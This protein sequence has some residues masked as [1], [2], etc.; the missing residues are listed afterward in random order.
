MNRH[1]FKFI[2]IFEDKTINGEP[3][4]REVIYYDSLEYSN[5]KSIAFIYASDFLLKNV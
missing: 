1:S 4:I 3:F 2:S 5:K